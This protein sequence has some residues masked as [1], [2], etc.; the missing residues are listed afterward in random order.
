MQHFPNKQVTKI[1]SKPNKM[2]REHSEKLY[3]KVLSLHHYFLTLISHIDKNTYHSFMPITVS[4]NI[5]SAEDTESLQTYI[6]NI[7]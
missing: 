2:K 5:A 6:S 4:M 1:S 3:L 7:F